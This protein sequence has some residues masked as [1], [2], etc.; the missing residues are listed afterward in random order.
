MK[1][2]QRFA[3]VA[4]FA[5]LGPAAGA[6]A[7]VIAGVMMNIISRY[8]DQ[9]AAEVAGTAVGSVLLFAFSLIIA[10]P[11]AFLPAALT[12]IVMAGLAGWIGGIRLWLAASVAVGAI[13]AAFL[14][15]WPF[16]QFLM[17]HGEGLVYMKAGAGAF[18]GLLS[19]AAAWPV[20]REQQAR[21]APSTVTA[22]DDW[23]A[24]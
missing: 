18:A 3:V 17:Q 13:S 5:T 15:G 9:S 6:A 19:A 21:S 2:G 14:T 7:I 24:G 23:S 4:I 20:V 1:P 8:P 16:F 11:T 22:A 12:G 10:F